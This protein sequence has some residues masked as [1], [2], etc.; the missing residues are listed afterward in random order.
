MALSSGMPRATRC[1][2]TMPTAAQ[3][4]ASNAD[5]IATA[6][7]ATHPMAGWIPDIQ[8]TRNSPIEGRRPDT[9][10]AIRNVHRVFEEGQRP[11]VHNVRRR[12]WEVRPVVNVGIQQLAIGGPHIHGCA[13]YR[14]KAGGDGSL[15]TAGINHRADG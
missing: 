4:A 11:G 6:C 1:R 3:N 13:G 5:T 7:S 8:A 10:G 15:H 9:A 14:V 2:T 12:R